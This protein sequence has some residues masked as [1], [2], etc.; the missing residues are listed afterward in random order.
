MPYAPPSVSVLVLALGVDLDLWSEGWWL[1]KVMGWYWSE[2]RGG[3][4]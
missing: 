2:E 3:S 4:S 1:V